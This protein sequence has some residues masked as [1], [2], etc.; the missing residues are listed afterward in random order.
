MENYNGD[1]DLE[2]ETWFNPENYKEITGY[3]E[4]DCDFDNQ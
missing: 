2:I 1:Y 3:W 4:D